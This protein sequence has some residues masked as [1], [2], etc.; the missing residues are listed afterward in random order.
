[1][2]NW[3]IFV[4]VGLFCQLCSNYEAFSPNASEKAGTSCFVFSINSGNWGGTLFS[5]LVFFTFFLSFLLSSFPLYVF[6][7]PKPSIVLYFAHL[8]LQSS[9]RIFLFFGYIFTRFYF[10]LTVSYLL[11]V[12]GGG[13]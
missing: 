4:I 12:M 6:S 2:A 10:P 1:V 7:H 9:I 3:L 5:V 11:R 8:P 13:L